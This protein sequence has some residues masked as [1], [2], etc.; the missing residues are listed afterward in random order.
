MK[1]RRNAVSIMS[2]MV[3]LIK[4]LK[5][6]MMAAILLGV[7]GFVLSF[8]IGIIGVYG[9]L[10]LLP[11]NISRGFESIPFG[12]YG[13]KTYIWELA[14]CALLR[15]VFHYIEQYCNHYIAFRIL[16]EIRHQIFGA[17]RSLAPAKLE[18]E[19]PGKLIS[20]IMGDIE[21]L[22]VFYAHTISPIMIAF[23]TFVL[24]MI[25][26]V[27]INP[28]LALIALISYLTIGVFIPYFASSMSKDIGVNIRENIGSLN[29]K[30]LDKLKGVREVI[31]YDYGKEVV[32]DIGKTT[33]ETLGFQL[34]L[35]AKVASLQSNTDTIIVVFSVIHAIVATKMV[36]S[37]VITPAEAFVSVFTQLSTF[38]PFIALANLGTTLSQTLA[39]GD[40]VM[41][42]LSEKPQVDFVDYGVD[43]NLENVKIEN[44]DFKYKDVDIL[45][46]LNL[47]ISKGETLGI[48]GRSGSGKSTILKLLMRFWDPQEGSISI[49]GIDLK[50][51]NTNSI[52]DNIDYM[53]QMTILFAGTIR[54]NL[55]VA[56]QNATDEDIY[57]ALR[58]A[59][60]DEYVR[61][62]KNGLDTRV[63][64]L[65]DNFSGGERQRIGLARCF[66]TDSK[67]LLLDEPTSN[68]DSQN[69]AIILKSL[70]DV[71]DKTIVLVSHRDS[72]MG[73]CDRVINIEK[74]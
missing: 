55:K 38:G 57:E 41:D 52:Y 11:D 23:F 27:N 17:M 46:N 3:K 65:G 70:V 21:L 5:F 48:R 40:R 73:V 15:G 16:A 72:T 33:E 8:G 74:I 69:E 4:P 66:L 63:S 45:N 9:M 67:L 32:E 60:I 19:N 68:L 2:E 53:T 12:G 6:Q 24:L 42:L 54:D 20:I 58:K 30:F 22:E 50:D 25:F 18:G 13:I 29:G 47:E 71:E 51:I 28:V 56:N 14:I 34:K 44:V 10:S 59:S 39:C 36:I 35:K 26:Y 31:Q 64:D 7:L 49:N 61:G 1:T 37:G 62:L 43:V